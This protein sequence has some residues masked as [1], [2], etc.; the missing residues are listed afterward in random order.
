MRGRNSVDWDD[1]QTNYQVPRSEPTTKGGNEK[2]VLGNFIKDPKMI[3]TLNRKGITRLLPIQYETFEFIY[4][5]LD[6]VAKD[7]TGSGK[8]IAFSLP[9][10]LRLREQKKFHG[11]RMT[12]FL[13]V[14]PTR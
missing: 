9:T 5:G 14:L 1:D 3:E 4:Q 8:T 10:I 6:V 13:I 12:R 7:R 11:P 2:G